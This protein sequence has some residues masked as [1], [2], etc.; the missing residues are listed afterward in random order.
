MS[1][2]AVKGHDYPKMGKVLTARDTILYLLSF[3]GYLSILKAVRLS[4]RHHQNR[5]E[6][7]QVSGNRAA[8][9]SS[10]DSVLER[11]DELATGKLGQESWENDK[12][13]E[14]DPLADMPFWSKDF[15]D[16]LIPTEVLAPAKSACTRTQY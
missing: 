9:S 15:T 2:S 7:L 1:G 6:T 3:L 10:S 16:N 12:K 11:S 5:W 13:D 4:K 8:A 14:N